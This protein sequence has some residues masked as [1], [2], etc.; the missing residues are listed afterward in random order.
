MQE[1]TFKCNALISGCSAVNIDP[2][3]DRKVE[4]FGDWTDGT[5]ILRGDHLVFTTNAINAIYQHEASDLLVQYSAITACQLSRMMKLFKTVDLK[6]TAGDLRFR[7]WGATNDA[8]LTDRK[9]RMENV[10]DVGIS[11]FDQLQILEHVPVSDSIN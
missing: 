7:C 3:I 10:P 2:Q 11:F 8:L 4:R 6:T 5:V 9:E 1:K